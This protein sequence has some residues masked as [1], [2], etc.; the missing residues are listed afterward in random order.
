M[1]ALNNI[2]FASALASGP[3]VE[4][5]GKS[6]VVSSIPM[7]FSPAQQPPP[8]HQVDSVALVSLKLLPPSRCL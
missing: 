3:E 6:R 1:N 5:L 4:G 8:P 2:P 7:T